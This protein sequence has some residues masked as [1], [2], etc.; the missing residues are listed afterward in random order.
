[1]EDWNMIEITQN[2]F[3]FL[4]PPNF[5]QEIEV[6]CL[7]YAID[8]L[9]QKFLHKCACVAIWSDSKNWTHTICDQLA[10]ELRTPLYS[11]TLPL[12]T[13]KE[14]VKKTL[15]WYKRLGTAKVAKEVTELAWK[16]TGIEE[17]FHAKNRQPYTFRIKTK[18]M[19]LLAAQ[20]ELLAR[21]EEVKNVR[22]SLEGFQF[23]TE[24]T[25]YVGSYAQ[26]V[27]KVKILPYQPKKQEQKINI[28]V[29]ATFACAEKLKICYQQ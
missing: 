3:L 27:E 5:K 26:T 16:S 22:S 24:Q 4:V 11:Q 21:M 18:D 25:I 19:S 29:G 12:D 9:F 10:L 7:A 13:K 6:Q 23:I 8:T 14:M 17:W 1:M 15:D 2:G 28:M 20:Q